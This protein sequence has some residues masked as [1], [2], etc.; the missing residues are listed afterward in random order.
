MKRASAAMLDVSAV[1]LS[2]LCLIHCLT[3]PLLVASL[4]ILG[5]WADQE[6]VHAVLV[7]I[8]AP[9]SGYALWRVRS[10]LPLALCALAVLG[11]G[12]LLAGALEWFGRDSETPLTLAG[13]LLLAAAHL[14][15][16]A[17]HSHP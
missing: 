9:L 7:A 2:G 13:S 8:A 6:W 15:N 17:R 11:L 3:L 5:V 16:W 12:C 10:R 1:L 14:W 4:P